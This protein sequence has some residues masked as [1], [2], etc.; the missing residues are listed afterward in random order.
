MFKARNRGDPEAGSK[1]GGFL[2]GSM[3]EGSRGKGQKDSAP[4]SNE[5]RNFNK[6]HPLEN[7][8]R[9]PQRKSDSNPHNGNTALESCV[10][11]REHQVSWLGWQRGDEQS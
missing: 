9:I 8:D 10:S 5:V 4:S 7:K 11:K 6:Q 2:K 1:G 3:L